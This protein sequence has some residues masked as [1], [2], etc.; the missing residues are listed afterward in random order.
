M[1][2]AYWS[3]LHQKG[4][5]TATLMIPGTGASSITVAALDAAHGIL[6]T[7]GLGPTLADVRK[8][9]IAA[10]GAHVGAPNWLGA[11]VAENR[12]DVDYAGDSGT[13]FA[14]PLVAGAIAL[15]LEKVATP[16]SC[17]EIKRR[18]LKAAMVPL[19]N[20]HRDSHGRLMLP[21]NPPTTQTEREQA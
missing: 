20:V 16:P 11:C 3:S 15:Q 17:K 4:D 5:E 7:S 9:D 2:G 19:Q 10:L 6:P 13:S 8:P 18:L 14:A 1:G 12:A 21:F